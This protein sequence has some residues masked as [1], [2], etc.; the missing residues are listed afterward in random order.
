MEILDNFKAKYFDFL[1][2]GFDGFKSKYMERLIWVGEKAV[3]KTAQNQNYSGVIAGIDENGFLI[4]SGKS[5]RMAIP[6]GDVVKQ[7]KAG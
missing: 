2:K 5:G 1:K 3:V 7:R 6:S 4:L